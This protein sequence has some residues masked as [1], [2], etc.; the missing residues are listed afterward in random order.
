MSKATQSKSSVGLATI[1][2]GG[3]SEEG[4]SI[5]VYVDLR[6]PVRRKMIT[7]RGQDHMREPTR[8]SKTT[9]NRPRWSRCFHD[10][11]TTCAKELRQHMADDLE[12]VGDV[13][14]LLG[15]IVSKCR[16]GPPQ[17]GQLSLPGAC[18]MVSRSRCSGSGFCS[19]R[20]TGPFSSSS[21][22]YRVPELGE[23]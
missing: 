13:P 17:S 11:I 5:G 8:S 6:L 10:A 3:A 18:L 19:G 23:R 15:N 1:S 7:E 16:N 21:L 14:E 22:L 4:Q 2:F 20:G 12:A 9:L